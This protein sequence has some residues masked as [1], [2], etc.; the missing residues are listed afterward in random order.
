MTRYFPSA[1]GVD[2]FMARLE[3]ALSGFGKDCIQTRD[4]VV[5]AAHACITFW[6]TGAAGN[7]AHAMQWARPNV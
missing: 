5:L 1:L 4:T 2:D 6:P 3:M 7:S